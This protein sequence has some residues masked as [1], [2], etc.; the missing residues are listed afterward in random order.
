MIARSFPFRSIRFLSVALLACGIVMCS[1]ATRERAWG[2]E[3]AKPAVLEPL[4][5]AAVDRAVQYG[6]QYLKRSQQPQGHWG[7]G[8]EPGVEED[9]P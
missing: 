4:D 3:P 5:Q 2:Q 1:S 7:A 6:V 9:G 8:K